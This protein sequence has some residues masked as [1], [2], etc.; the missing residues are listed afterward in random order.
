MSRKPR[1]RPAKTTQPEIAPAPKTRE[2]TGLS[3]VSY[4]NNGACG[5]ARAAEGLRSALAR[6]GI[7]DEGDVNTVLH[8]GEPAAWRPVLAKFNVGLCWWPFSRVPDA[9]TRPLYGIDLLIAPSTWCAEGVV[10]PKP[11][12]RIGVVPMG[13]DGETFAISE[14]ERGDTLRLM[15][16]D[17]GA[18]EYRAGVDLAVRAFKEAFPGRDDVSLDIFTTRPAD[19]QK[20]DPRIQIRRN[21]GDDANLARLYRQYDALIYSSRGEGVGF[22]ALEAM[23]TALPVIHSGQTAM[24]DFADVGQ[25]VGSRK[26]R[27]PVLAHPLAETF[28]PWL[29]LLTDRLRQFDAQYDKWQTKAR[30]D[31]E[32][33]REKWTWERSARRLLD[34]LEG[35][36]VPTEPAD[37]SVG[38]GL[39]SVA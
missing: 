16:F 13:V 32:I 20:D 7:T 24:A 31:A 22:V 33:V 39:Q 36:D 14:R 37:V 17:S 8:I 23:A 27:V 30:D 12:Q 25:L 1:R 4:A 35:R 9:F 29:D 3:I 28:E 15:F 5:Y 2:V 21:I 38:R 6:I 34:V 11:N 10:M 18:A 26:V 19:I